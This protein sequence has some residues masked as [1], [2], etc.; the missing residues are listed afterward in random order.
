MYVTARSSFGSMV[1]HRRVVLAM[2]PGFVG[3]LV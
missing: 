2:T 3:F 1:H